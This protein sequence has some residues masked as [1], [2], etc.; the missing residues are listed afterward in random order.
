MEPTRSTD[1]FCSSFTT[2]LSWNL[3]GLAW[4]CS[5]GR[6][7]AL[8]T[9]FVPLEAHD[10]QKGSPKGLSA[11]PTITAATTATNCFT[12]TLSWNRPDL[13]TLLVPPLPPRF[14]GTYQVYFDRAV[15]AGWQLW[16]PFLFLLR[17]KT[18]KK[19]HQRVCQQYLL[20]PLLL[21]LLIALLIALPPHYQVDRAVW[22][23]WQLWWPFLFLL[24]PKMV[25]K[26][27]Q[28]VC[29][30]Y[31]LLPLLL[32]LLIALLPRFHGTDQISFTTTLS[33]NLP[34]LP[35]PC[36]LGRLAALATLFVPPEAQNGQKGSPKGLSAVPTTT[37]ATTATN[38][39]TTTLS[40]NR[41]DLR[42]LFVP[43]LPP[44]FHGTCQVYLDCAV[45]A[46][47]QLWR[48]FLFLLRPKTV[49]KGHQRVCQQYLLLP[50]LLLLLIPLLP[51]FHGTDQIYGP[52]LF[53]LYHHA[54]MEPTRSTLTVQFGP[55]G[56]SGDP[57]CSSWGPKRSKR[58]MKGSVSSTYYYRC[59]YCY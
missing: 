37:A 10:S 52:F 3:P 27:H 30:Q 44:R 42:T 50:L 28:R 17:P 11:V 33:W 19:G 53:L 15:W 48:P 7:A 57:F 14:H 58:V 49:K 24:R 34:G 43:P 51:R 8:A 39:F 40:W 4:P 2:T 54:F 31:L 59:N 26:G 47:W 25:K 38:S 45:W 56:S 16:R 12:T 23:G 18:V 36:S 32:L 35:W 55:A 13:R 20:L 29:Q 6:L 9:L 46:G 1:P 5:L 41:P 22:A 21:L